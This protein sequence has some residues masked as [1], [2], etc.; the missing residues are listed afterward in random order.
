MKDE[1]AGE[2]P[3]AFAVKPEKSQVTEDEIKQYISKQVNPTLQS[4]SFLSI[5]KDKKRKNR[6]RQAVFP[7]VSDKRT[8]HEF[9]DA[10]DILQE[11]KTSFLHRSYSQGTI[12]QNPEEK[13]ERKVGRHIIEDVTENLTLYFI[14]LMIEKMSMYQ[15][16]DMYQT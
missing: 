2:V 16:K 9:D 8:Q 4:I 11:N 12:G 13:S 3:V 10:G 1:D 5:E 15:G 14:S 7:L 6:E